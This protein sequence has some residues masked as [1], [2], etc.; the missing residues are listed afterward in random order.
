MQ[1]KN[2]NFI[3]SKLVENLF[4]S[5]RC[6]AAMVVMHAGS[7]DAMDSFGKPIK[8]PMLLTPGIIG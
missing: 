5:W 6:V 2:I 4:I 7:A 8:H 1:F 3:D